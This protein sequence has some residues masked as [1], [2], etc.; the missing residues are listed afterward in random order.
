[1]TDFDRLAAV[2]EEVLRGE[3]V[4][5][6]DIRL[7]RG[8]ARI[9]RGDD[10]AQVAPQLKL[11]RRGL[12]ATV[13]GV[14]TKGLATFQKFDATPD[15][16]SL[17]KKRNGI[18]QMLLGTLGERRFEEVIRE[19]TGKGALS[20]ED[21]RP[22]RSDTDYRLLNGG[23]KPVCRL[24]IKWHGTFFR[25]AKRYVGLEPNDCFALA[26]YKIRNALRREDQEDLPYV[27]VVFSVPNLIIGD[28]EQLVPQEY[29]WSLAVVKGKRAVEEAI[30]ERLRAP[31]YLAQFSPVYD[32]M[33]QGQF[34]VISVQKAH[35]LLHEKLFER[36]H[37]LTLKGFT[38]R[39]RNAEVDMHFSLT[40]DLTP[41]QKFLEMLTT[42]SAQVA[43]VKLTKGKEY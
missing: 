36:V 18:A 27:F 21:H 10:S 38:S 43:T 35:R 25:D 6:R 2:I 22:S 4:R 8:V 16:K 34:R 42:E 11:Q 26:T 5:D 33:R 1:M 19:V 23:G 13:D 40:E 29:A 15:P 20:I 30:V 17:G 32:R 12:E 24:N 39:F 7:V 9:L 3:T 41:V 31:D 14:R 37:A 28:V